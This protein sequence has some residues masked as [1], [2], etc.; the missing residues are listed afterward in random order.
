MEKLKPLNKKQKQ[1]RTTTT[2]TTIDKS[3]FQ[4]TAW[5]TYTYLSFKKFKIG[6]YFKNVWKEK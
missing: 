2:T 6:R 1:I 4:I 5:Y 3:L